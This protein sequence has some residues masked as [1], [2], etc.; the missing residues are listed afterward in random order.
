[1]TDLLNEPIAKNITPV[2]RLNIPGGGQITVQDGLAFVGH[3]DAPNGTT[4]ID[5]KNPSK[6][7]VLKQIFLEDELSH[8]HKVRV[9]GKLMITNVEQ[10]QR[11]LLRKGEQLPNVIR[12]LTAS[13]NRQPDDSEIADALGLPPSKLADV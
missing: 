3:M 2:A 13:L 5:I 4:I 1:M 10:A 7:K 9:A 6:P 8:T 11:H 12:T